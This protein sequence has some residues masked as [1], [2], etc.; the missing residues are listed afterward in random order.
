MNNNFSEAPDAKE[1][2]A[3]SVS[4]SLLSG[5]CGNIRIL[6]FPGIGKE[7]QQEQAYDKQQEGAD[8]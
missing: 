6:F 8:E 4:P 7:F 1:G 2:D 3:Q 5:H